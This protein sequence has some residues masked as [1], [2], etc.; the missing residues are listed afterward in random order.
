VIN[1]QIILVISRIRSICDNQSFNSCCLLN[2]KCLW[3]P[4]DVILVIPQ[5]RSFSDKHSV[6]ISGKKF[7]V[8]GSVHHST[9]YKNPTRCNRVSNF[10]SSYLYEVQHVSGDTP[11]IIRSLKTALAASGFAYVEGCWTLWLLDANSVQQPHVPQPS[12]YHLDK[13]KKSESYMW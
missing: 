3:S 13:P 2:T 8:R 7:D 4:L 9:I 6:T 1:T 12:T 11:P 10:I 5:I